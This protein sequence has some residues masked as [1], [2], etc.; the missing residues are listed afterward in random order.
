[1]TSS[2]LLAA[3]I[4]VESQGD[5]RA[6]GDR[7]EAHGLLQIHAAVI[8]DVN[9][10]TGARYTQADAFDPSTAAA[11]CT[12]YLAHYATARRLGR[13][14]TDEDRARIWNGGPNGWRDRRTLVFWSR[15]RA[16][17]AK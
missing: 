2:I 1:M 7:G 3:L 5:P 11:I 12:A 9:G 4:L 8:M 10:V 17:M 6:V 16:A 15:V 13:P 14:P